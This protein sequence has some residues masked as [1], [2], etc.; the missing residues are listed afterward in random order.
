MCAGEWAGSIIAGVL[1]YGAVI[2]TF[3]RSLRLFLICLP[4][5]GV[6]PIVKRRELKEKRNQEFARQF[7]EGIL[8][9]AASLNAGY[10]VE[11]AFS[12]SLGELTVLYGTNGMITVEFYSIAKKLAMK[13]PVEQALLDLARRSGLEDVENFAQVFAA[14]KRSGG[15][16][17]PIIDHTVN[18]I[19]EKMQVREEILTMTASRQ[20]EQRIMNLIPFFLVLYI[21]MTSPGFFDVM[22]QTVF[23]RAVMTCCLGVYA[24]AFWMSKKLLQIEV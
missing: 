11:N 13:E 21:N 8:I 7:K 23:G 20:F 16:L 22:Y 3:Y 6:Y 18:V 12:A 1:I 19:R 24:F 17:V 15:R 10:S 14:A 2:F 5:S 4:I 9:L